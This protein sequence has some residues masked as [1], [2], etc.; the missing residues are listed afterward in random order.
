[1]DRVRFSHR[2][3]VR[4][5]ILLALATPLLVQAG[6]LDSWLKKGKAESPRAARYDLAPPLVFD[7]GPLAVDASGKWVVGATRLTMTSATQ[8]YRDNQRLDPRDLRMGQE[9]RVM[10]YPLGDGSIAVYRLALYTRPTLVDLD[11]RRSGGAEVG[12]LPPDARY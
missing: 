7:A 4:T 9:A 6:L 5:I 11:V 3:I 1:M 8:I 2:A 10:G 12:E